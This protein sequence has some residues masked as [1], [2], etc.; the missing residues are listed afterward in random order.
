M[1]EPRA[2]EGRAHGLGGR[3]AAPGRDARGGPALLRPPAPPGRAPG[4]APGPSAT[5]GTNE[6]RGRRGRPHGR[7][8]GRSGPRTSAAEGCNPGMLARR[9]EAAATPRG[10]MRSFG[11]HGR[12]LFRRGGPRGGGPAG[13][14]PSRSSCSRVPGPGGPGGARSPGSFAAL[15]SSTARSQRPRAVRTHRALSR[16]LPR[17]CPLPPSTFCTRDCLAG[18]PGGLQQVLGEKLTG[19][20]S[21]GMCPLPLPPGMVEHKRNL[22]CVSPFL[23]GLDV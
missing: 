14:C 19:R 2:G 9:G 22:T 18:E 5:A 20:P 13:C 6:V 16:L 1:S 3:A 23:L 10:P 7:S 8:G 21:S 17:R 15:S 12:Q 4:P 11:E